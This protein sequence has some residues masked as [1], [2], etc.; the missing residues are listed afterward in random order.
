M[1]Q[2]FEA[3]LKIHIRGFLSEFTNHFSGFLKTTARYPPTWRYI[4]KSSGEIFLN[5]ERLR[6]V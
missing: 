6:P 1:A 5:V 4:A 3:Y 2:T